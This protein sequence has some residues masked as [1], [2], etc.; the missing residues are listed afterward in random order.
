MKITVICGAC[1]HHAEIS[2]DVLTDSYAIA[3]FSEMGWM[4]KRNEIGLYEIKCP[5]CTG[6]EEK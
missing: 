2:G 1:G 6:K 3:L 4:I 5:E